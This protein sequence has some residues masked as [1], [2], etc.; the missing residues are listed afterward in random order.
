M[1]GKVRCLFSTHDWNEEDY[2]KE[3]EE[4]GHEVGEE[5]FIRCHRCKKVIVGIEKTPDGGIKWNSYDEESILWDISPEYIKREGATQDINRFQE[6]N[7]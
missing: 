4:N 6:D 3:I 7:K 5:I 2:N 1:F